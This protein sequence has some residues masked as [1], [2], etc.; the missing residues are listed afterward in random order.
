[1]TIHDFARRIATAAGLGGFFLLMVG[2][3]C[4]ANNN[5]NPAIVLGAIGAVL[6]GSAYAITPPQAEPTGPDETA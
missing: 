5:G 1:M 2:G 4:W 6:I 3:I